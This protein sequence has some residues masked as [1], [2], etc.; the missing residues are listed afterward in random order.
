MTAIAVILAS[1]RPGRRGEAVARWVL[2]QAT[3]RDDATFELVDLAEHHLPAVDEPFPPALGRYTLDHTRA[4]AATV[5]RFDGYVF[6][7]PEYN[8]AMP[9]TLKNAL[10][11]V[12]AEWNSKSAGV[13]SYGV[14]GGIRAAEQLRLVLGALRVADVGPQVAFN[15]FTDFEGPDLRPSDRHAGAL[16]AVLDDVVTWGSALAPL[17]SRSRG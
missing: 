16:S 11:R 2:D 14:E 10:D 12:Y 13:V 9:G 3:T 8:H 7:T 15:V 4:W 5:A 17:R 6:V 1:T